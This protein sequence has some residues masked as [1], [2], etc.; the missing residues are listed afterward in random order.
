MKLSNFEANERYRL[1]YRNND[2]IPCIFRLA[3]HARLV[4]RDRETWVR[5]PFRAKTNFLDGCVELVKMHLMCLFLSIPFICLKIS[6]FH[7]G[8][9]WYV[10]LN[11]LTH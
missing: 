10:F 2:H 9:S 1:C 6:N 11:E 7:A 3:Q 8:I 5:V 4:I